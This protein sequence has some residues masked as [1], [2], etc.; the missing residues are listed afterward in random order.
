M[1]GPYMAT[2]YSTKNYVVRLTEAI[3]EELSAEN[4]NVY[5]GALCPGPVDTN[6]NNTAGVSF[7]LKGITSEYA[8]KYAVDNMFRRKTLIVPTVTMKAAVIGSSLV[9]PLL[10][11]KITRHM[12]SRKGQV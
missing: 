8:A 1:P 12:Q 3:H 5:V 2:Y 6:F 10:L 4:S 7:S 9:P 11:A